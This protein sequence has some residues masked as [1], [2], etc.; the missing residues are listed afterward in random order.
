MHKIIHVHT[1]VHIAYICIQL[2]IVESGCM[3]AELLSALHHA[4][5]IHTYTCTRKTYYC[6]CNVQCLH[7]EHSYIC[8]VIWVSICLF[9]I[10][11]VSTCHSTG[12]D[13]ETEFHHH[14]V[15]L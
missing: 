3:A 4:M 5:T 10:S 7:G 15:G 1:Y 8:K 11:L 6:T 13:S 9:E 12:V 14:V 2:F